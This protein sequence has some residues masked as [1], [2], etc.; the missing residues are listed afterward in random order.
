MSCT[1]SVC[2][3]VELPWNLAGYNCMECSGP[4]MIAYNKGIININADD[5]Y[6][7][8]STDGVLMMIKLWINE[9]SQLTH[10]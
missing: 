8:Q 5:Q 2:S 10:N 1:G 3:V 7:A 4:P 6:R 9:Y